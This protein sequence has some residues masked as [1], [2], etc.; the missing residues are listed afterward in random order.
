M[1]I[2]EE[3][4]DCLIVGAGVVGLSI[5]KHLLQRGFSVIVIDKN[6]KA[7]EEISSRNSGVIHS[8]VYYPKNSLKAQM[9]ITGKQLLYE[10][11]DE[12]NISF[13]KTGKLIVA[14]AESEIKHLKELYENGINNGIELEFLSAEQ[15]SKLEP[16]ISCL[17]GIHSPTTGIVDVHELVNVLEADIQKLGGVISFRSRFMRSSK[18]GSLFHTQINSEEDI[19]IKSK[20]FI[21]S[22]GLYSEE[23]ANN[24]DS[25]NKD[26]INNVEFAKGHYLKYHGK[27]PFSR[28]IYPLPS[29]NGLGIH[30][31]IDIDGQLKFGP[32]VLFIDKIDYSFDN[33]LID[34]FYK[35]INRYWPNV[36]KDKLHEDYSGI[37]PKIKKGNHYIKDFYIGLPDIHNV[38]GLVLLQG[39]ESPGLTSSLALGKYISD[40]L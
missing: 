35:E 26:F 22:A 36:K 21:N 24:L 23:V 18:Q 30:S 29:E 28:L 8:G 40:S 2:F 14:N 37:R 4:F 3:S 25:L 11:C 34:K 6:S 19:V 39:I 1:E 20:I 9:C 38:K 10:Y 33:G 16:E 13:K 7:G 32:D 31:T 17:A 27:N 12:K 5:S 15:S